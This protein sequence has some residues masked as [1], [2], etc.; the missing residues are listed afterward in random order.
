MTNREAI[1]ELKKQYRI[2]INDDHGIYGLPDEIRI[3]IKAIE[4]NE[5]LKVRLKEKEIH[6]HWIK[7]GG[8]NNCIDYQCSNCKCAFIS[9]SEY[10]PNCG[11]Q[12]DDVEK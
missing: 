3:A 1:E 11:A 8:Y 9:K 5:Q 10:C 6:A 2:Y 7:R 4:E 12:I